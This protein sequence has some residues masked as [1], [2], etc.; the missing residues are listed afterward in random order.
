ML[1]PARTPG[2]T[3]TVVAAAASAGSSSTRAA[4]HRD[5]LIITFLLERGS[6]PCDGREDRRGRG[7]VR[8]AP[9]KPVAARPAVPRGLCCARSRR[10][11][12]PTEDPMTRPASRRLPG[13]VLALLALGARRSCSRSRPRAPPSTPP[14][15]R[16]SSATCR[17]WAARRS[18]TCAPCTRARRSQAFG[19]SGRGRV[20]DRAPRPL[21]HPLRDR[22]DEDGHR[23]RRHGRLADRPGRQGPAARRQG[24]RR[25]EGRPVVRVRRLAAAR[26]GRRLGG[27]GGGGVRLRRPLRRARADAARGP[28]APRV[29]RPDVRAAGEGGLE[30]RPADGDQPA[31]RLPRRRRRA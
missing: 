23:L 10:S 31:R 5:F 21:R 13:A 24:P 26:P 30:E 20:V 15:A 16:C 28:V 8:Q 29:L 2:S 1:R 22:A 18:S 6:I 7:G 17:P 19:M 11:P 25:G 12:S 9:D 27:L 3:V 14:P 4:A